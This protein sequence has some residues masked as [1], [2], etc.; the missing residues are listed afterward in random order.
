MQ[1]SAAAVVRSV[2]LRLAGLN[3][4]Q[5]WQ[6]WCSAA[7]EPSIAVSR[8]ALPRPAISCHALP[9]AVLPTV[10]ALLCQTGPPQPCP[11]CPLC[12][13]CPANPESH[14]SPALPVPGQC[15]P[16]SHTTASPRQTTLHSPPR[17]GWPVQDTSQ[18]PHSQ[19]GPRLQA[20]GS[21]V[22]AAAKASAAAEAAAMMTRGAGL[23]VLCT[24][25]WARLGCM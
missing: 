4:Q 25:G 13:L 20:A 3:L 17:A 2:R 23:P 14:A 7:Q 5:R 16:R 10:P 15:L 12:Q 21:N 9:S 11:P 6:Q 18:Q 22:M 24:G 19:T 1:C 8:R